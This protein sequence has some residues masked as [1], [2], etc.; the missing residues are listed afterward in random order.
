M[1]EPGMLIDVD[2]RY[3]YLTI[4]RPLNALFDGAGDAEALQLDVT[5][6]ELERRPVLFGPADDRSIACRL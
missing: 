1:L 2:D 5:D 6:A 3:V 4:G